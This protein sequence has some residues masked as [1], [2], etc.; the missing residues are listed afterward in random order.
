MDTIRFQELNSKLESWN[1]YA[2]RL[3]HSLDANGVTAAGKKR[4]H[5]L[6]YIGPATYPATYSLLTGLVSPAKLTDKSYDD[7]VKALSEHYDPKPSEMVEQFKFHTRT[8]QTG[9]SITTFVSELRNIARNCNFTSLNDLLR[10]RL[11]CGINDD[12]IQRRLLAETQ[13]LTFDRA[14]EITLSM[15]AA[16][17]HVTEIQQSRSAAETDTP[18]IFSEALLQMW[19]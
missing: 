19:C 10:D 14:M 18:D 11:V 7:L 16:K 5:L 4:S 9:E 17:Q 12:G 13:K 6:S 2:E 1:Q 3:G 15:E 8:R